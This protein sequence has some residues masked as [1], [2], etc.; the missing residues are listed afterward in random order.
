MR[1]KIQRFITA[2]LMRDPNYPLQDNEPL[3][4][5]GLIDSFSLVQLQLFIDQQFGIH[6]DDTELTVEAIDNVDDIMALI[7]TRL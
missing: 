4:S 5:G 6:I 3:I 2:E 7:E 1:E